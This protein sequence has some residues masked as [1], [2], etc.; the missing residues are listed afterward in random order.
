MTPD[1]PNILDEAK[2]WQPKSYPQHFLDSGLSDSALT[3][4]AYENAPLKFREP[5]DETIDRMNKVVLKSIKNIEAALNSTRDEEL[6]ATATTATRLLQRLIDVA[7]AI[8]HGDTPNM[9][10]S[11]IDDLLND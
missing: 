10:Q 2:I 8:I 1:M 6:V 9:D 5:F 11:E 4:E 7:G 3:I